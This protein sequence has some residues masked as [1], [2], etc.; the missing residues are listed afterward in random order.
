MHDL[1]IAAARSSMVRAARL[2]S[3]TSRSTA[4]ASSPWARDLGAAREEIDA[5]GKIVTPGFV[6]VHTHYDG[7]GDMGCRNGAVELARGDHRRDG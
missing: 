1:V 7:Q 3:P 6:D 5:A 2:S 4:T